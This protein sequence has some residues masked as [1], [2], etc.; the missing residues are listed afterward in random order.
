MSTRDIAAVSGLA[1]STVDKLSKLMSWRTVGMGTAQAFTIACGVNLLAT[2]RQRE[3]FRRR[4]LFYM[5]H[6]TPAQRKMY[7]N[8]KVI[9][10]SR[11]KG[12]A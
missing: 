2:S 7:A 1:P 9:L 3:F 5:K 8:L 11:G 4:G 12:S 10:C 6:C